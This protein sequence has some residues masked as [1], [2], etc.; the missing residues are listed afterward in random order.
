MK[1]ERNLVNSYFSDCYV[2][3]TVLSPGDTSGNKKEE[4]R[5]KEKECAFHIAYLSVSEF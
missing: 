5:K 4:K 2:P 3:G 1:R